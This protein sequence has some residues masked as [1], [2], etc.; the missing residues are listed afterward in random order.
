MA[1]LGKSGCPSGVWEGERGGGGY[2]SIIME[3]E[4]EAGH[5][6]SGEKSGG[7]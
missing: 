7:G 4:E 5:R 3:G 1:E 6:G 2:G